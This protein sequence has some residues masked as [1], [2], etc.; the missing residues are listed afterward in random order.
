M[1]SRL[2]SQPPKQVLAAVNVNRLTDDLVTSFKASKLRWL[3][4]LINVIIK[5]SVVNPYTEDQPHHRSMWLEQCGINFP[6]LYLASFYLYG[7]AQQHGY[8]TF[9]FA[10]R[11]C[12]HWI[13]IFQQ[14]F[15]QLRE[16][17]HYF[18]CSRNMFQAAQKGRH[19]AFRKYVTGLT[20]GSDLSK[21]IYI[22][23][24]GTGQNMLSYF[25][26][27]FGHGRSPACLLLSA[28]CQRYDQLPAICHAPRQLDRLEVLVFSA[29][30][31]P[32]EMLNYDTMGTLQDYVKRQGPIRS[33]PEYPLELL[34]PYHVCMAIL[35]DQVTPVRS[36]YLKQIHLAEIQDLIQKLYVI[37]QSSQPTIGVLVEH[38]V[39]HPS[40]LGT[41]I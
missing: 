3:E 6:L 2:D 26:S 20:G 12:C 36:R 31:T 16:Q 11:D 21:V 41:F 8:Q 24:H 13:R 5:V 9:L 10:T 32:I 18:H 33:P 23:I 7:Y 19:S 14:M 38:Q 35:I 17:C 30:G 1:N 39:K 40:K 15:P 25:E 28:S 22:D 29:A 34:E 4:P 37:I 27:V